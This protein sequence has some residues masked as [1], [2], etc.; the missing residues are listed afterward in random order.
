MG[1][2]VSVGADW[3]LTSPPTPYRVSENEQQQLA[4]SQSATHS[5][6]LWVTVGHQLADSPLLPTAHSRSVKVTVQHTTTS[7]VRCC[8]SCR[9]SMVDGRWLSGIGVARSLVVS[10]CC[11]SVEGSGS[12]A[13]VG[14]VSK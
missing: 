7:P 3:V 8:V 9:R 11:R 13:E 10:R 12:V 4:V 6:P 5:H 1:A 14:E 2:W